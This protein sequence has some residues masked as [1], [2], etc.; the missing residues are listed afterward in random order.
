MKRLAILFLGLI[1]AAAGAPTV[2]NVTFD[3][4]SHS[5]ALITF[6]V[7]SNYDTWRLYYSVAPDPC[8][9]SGK[10]IAAV[11][12]HAGGPDGIED[13]L[14]GM[15]VYFT[16]QQAGVSYNV[17]P[18][19]TDDG[20]VTWS[21][22]SDLL[23]PLAP[24]PTVH[25]APPN[26]PFSMDVSMPNL[27]GATV[28]HSSCST[29]NSD[30]N[31]AG[32]SD[33]INN[34]WVIDLPAG[35]VCPPGSLGGFNNQIQFP[36]RPNDLI[37]FHAANIHATSPG[38]IDFPTATFTEGQL[39]QL[40]RDVTY[41][42]NYPNTNNACAFGTGFYDGAKFFTHIVSDNGTTQVISLSCW[43]TGSNLNFSDTGSD[44]GGHGFIVTP[45]YLED[46][47]CPSLQGTSPC[48]Y[49]NRHLKEIIIRTAAPDNS[50]PPQGSRLTPDY[51]PLLVTFQNIQAHEG[52]NTI[53]GSLINFG[54]NDTGDN[55][56]VGK[57]RFIGIKFTNEV[58]PNPDPG[59]YCSMILHRFTDSFVI[60]DRD[61][62]DGNA[63]PQRWGFISCP[64]SIMTGFNN[65][66]INSSIVNLHRWN[67][68][69][70]VDSSSIIV[71]G[72][73]PQLFYNNYIECAGI[74]LHV[75][76]GDE[77]LHGFHGD[78]SVIRNYFYEPFEWMHGST[79]P[80]HVSD[81][82]FYGNRQP[83][84]IKA[85]LRCSTE[86]NYFQ[87]SWSEI[88]NASVFN[89]FT[90][91]G[92]T[93]IIDTMVHSNIYIHGPGGVNA[94]INTGRGKL[95]PLSNR[96]EFSNN[97]L[98]DINETYSTSDVPIPGA[99]GRGWAFQGP[100]G[101]E[102]YDIVNNTWVGN[103]GCAP[104]FLRLTNYPI[105]GLKIANNFMYLNNAGGIAGQGFSVEG[106]Y[107]AGNPNCNGIGGEATLNCLALT[108][109]IV[110]NN[111]IMSGDSDQATVQGWFPTLK[112]TNFIPSNMSL[113]ATP[114]WT[115]YN[116][117]GSGQYN[118]TAV[119]S[120]NSSHA[121]HGADGNDIGVNY[122]QLMR[123]QGHVFF[124]NVTQISSNSIKVPFTAPDSQACPVDISTDPLPNDHN[125]RFAD[126]GTAA[127]PRQVSISGLS[128]NTYYYGRINCVTHVDFNFKTN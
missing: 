60:F 4:V 2:S 56:N 82:H 47:N 67:D 124:D 77:F 16:G 123:D 95:G 26:P 111:V 107:P 46:G 103:T 36:Q 105:E 8:E 33:R 90:S 10:F 113:S 64:A 19:V 97:L 50:L 74:C 14:S 92:K 37:W 78:V 99:C 13:L 24:L 12:D 25:P 120:F 98:L 1:S 18:V 100:G 112:L 63:T 110:K 58:D 42:A 49:W 125:L 104:N 75:D 127:G 35:T 114:G 48:Q 28:V 72:P 86:G 101:G 7:S 52:D 66:V 54:D 70:G 115:N 89:A 96:F 73:G 88:T 91:V 87:D 108:N 5:V 29:L 55:Y 116:A 117:D 45:Y 51:A 11:S 40:S 93:G 15:T 65:A 85:C 102:D 94:P 79:I 118:L 61:L 128:P 68:T 76:D 23:V 38:T 43:E 62:L 80:G 39:I 32:T 3:Y 27:T 71:N 83:F 17:C 53:N 22:P 126:S 31:T 122:W 6:D 69:A 121:S 44:S 34:L 41:N 84:E 81:G 20:G 21:T 109:L 119:S 30:I 57:I 106:G 9:T 59:S